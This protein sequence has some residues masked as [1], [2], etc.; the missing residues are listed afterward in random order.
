MPDRS[1][2]ILNLVNH[3]GKNATDMTSALKKIGDGDMQKRLDTV[4][5][6]FENIGINIGEKNG[7][8]KG[9]ATTLGITLMIGG[10]ICLVNKYKKNRAKKELE[11]TGE[12]IYQALRETGEQNDKNL[13]SLKEKEEN[14]INKCDSSDEPFIDNNEQNFV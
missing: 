6:Y 7:W 3:N 12:K 1:K 2:D 13:D 4:A 10:G 5:R 9:S 8:I 11:L 14:I